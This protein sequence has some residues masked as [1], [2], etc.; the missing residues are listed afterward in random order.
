MPLPEQA[1]KEIYVQ[2]GESRLVSEPAIF[3]TVLGSC[4]GITFL[5]PRLGVGA[6]CHPMMPR[7][8]PNQ[9]GKLSVHA[10]RCY[11][12]FAIREMAQ[13]LDSRGAAR[14]EVVVKLFGGNDVLTTISGHPRPTIGRLN[15][16][17]AM[18]VLEEEGFTVTASCLGG[19]TGVH[20]Q[21]ETA[22]GEVLLRRLNSGRR[23]E[24]LRTARSGLRAGVS[25]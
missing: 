18:Q 2:P 4:V 21:F 16:E 14:A 10:T 6:L 19:T 8:P 13:K 7:C 15:R 9:L 12:D 11:V 3:R 24:S 5:V 22:T 23:L 1:V 17:A 20:I 25:R